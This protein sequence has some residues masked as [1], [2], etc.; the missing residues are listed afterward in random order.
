M[1]IQHYLKLAKYIEFLDF[2]AKTY[3]LE[4]TDCIELAYNTISKRKG[5]MIDGSFVKEK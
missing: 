1:K 5:K 4:L 2:T 3:N